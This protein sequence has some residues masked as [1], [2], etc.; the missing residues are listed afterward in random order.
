MDELRN[1]L[2]RADGCVT[3]AKEIVA[4]QLARVEVLRNADLSAALSAQNTLDLFIGTLKAL[5]DHVRLLRDEI[6]ER[7]E[8]RNEM[9]KRWE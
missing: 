2:E 3:Q 1:E 8:L 9:L 5:E 6:A 4:R 7:A